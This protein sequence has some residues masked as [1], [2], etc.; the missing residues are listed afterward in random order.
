M[1]YLQYAAIATPLMGIQL[2][3]QRPHIMPQLMHQQSTTPAGLC[4]C[5]LAAAHPTQQYHNTSFLSQL[6]LCLHPTFIPPA[7][8]FHHLQ[9]NSASQLHSYNQ[10]TP[11]HRGAITKPA[12]ALS[13][14][15]RG[16]FTNAHE[17]AAHCALLRIAV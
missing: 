11:A 7:A 15:S 10:A 14:S 4:S 1:D 3:Q 2:T 16:A 9:S 5:T 8:I 12:T 6:L 17:A 13:C